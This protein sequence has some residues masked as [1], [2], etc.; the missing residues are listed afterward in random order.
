MYFCGIELIDPTHSHGQLSQTQ[1]LGHQP[2]LPPQQKQLEEVV[3][4]LQ[5]EREKNSELEKHILELESRVRELEAKIDS[6]KLV[7]RLSHQM[8][9]LIQADGLIVHGPD[10]TENFST[11]SLDRVA[12][13]IQRYAPGVYE[14]FN[15]LGDTSRNV[16]EKEGTCSYSTEQRKTLLNA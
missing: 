15:Q 8:D 9:S 3:H 10:T 2:T 4:Q 5:A 14:L 16:Q 11:F 13:E 1:V 12:K 6:M 7:D